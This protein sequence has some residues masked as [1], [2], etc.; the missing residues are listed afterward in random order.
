[1]GDDK[2]VL[3]FMTTNIGDTVRIAD[4]LFSVVQKFP[5]ERR[6]LLRPVEREWVPSRSVNEAEYNQSKPVLVRGAE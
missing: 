3:T 2:L 4:E 6:L 5:T 1:M